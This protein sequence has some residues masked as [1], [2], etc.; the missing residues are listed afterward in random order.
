MVNERYPVCW[1]WREENLDLPDNCNLA[2]GRLKSVIKRLRQNPEMLKMYKNVIKDQLNKG[3]VESVDDNSI[4]G[5]LKHYIP[6]HAVV[7]PSKKT[8]KLRIVYDTA[9]KTKKS[10]ASLNECLYLGS[11]ILEDLCAL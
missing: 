4:Q 2:Y 6:H 5:K 11:V 9:A 10:N 8:T 3:V 7:I 1:P